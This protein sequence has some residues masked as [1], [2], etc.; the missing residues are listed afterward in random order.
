MC[1]ITHQRH[2]RSGIA[3]GMQ[4][5]QRESKPRRHLEDLA[6]AGLGGPGERTREVAVVQRQQ[7]L[8][9]RRIGTP[10]DRGRMPARERGQRQQRERA[11]LQEALPCRVRVGTGGAD[12]GND[13]ALACIARRRLDATQR[14]DRGLRAIRAHHQRRLHTEAGGELHLRRAAG[15]IGQT[16]RD[17]RLAAAQ[18]DAR[19]RGERAQQRC[20]DPAVL[21]EI[22]QLRCADIGCIE[23]DAPGAV[24]FPDPHGL[25]G[26]TR[27]IGQCRPGACRFEHAARGHVDGADARVHISDAGG[28]RGQSRLWLACLAEEHVQSLFGQ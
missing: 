26:A 7:P 9:H 8:G 19:L 28:Q 6:A 11:A 23:A 18:L 16:Q 22:S 5:P 3:R 15:L 17:Q 13:G 4:L 21:D 24:F 1:G 25:V 20:R 12:R 27:C 10:H 14:T 2:A